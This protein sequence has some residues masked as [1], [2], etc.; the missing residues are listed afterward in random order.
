MKKTEN[1]VSFYD[2]CGINTEYDE[3]EYE[4]F[5]L[6]YLKGQVIR[7]YLEHAKIIIEMN[8]VSDIDFTVK[9]EYN[10]FCY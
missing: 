5:T 7:S 2:T 1:G 3:R 6:P 8:G 4:R 10:E 9:K